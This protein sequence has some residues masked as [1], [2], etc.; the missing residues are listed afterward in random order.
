MSSPRIGRLGNIRLLTYNE[1]LAARTVHLLEQNQNRFVSVS[2]KSPRRH[3][4]GTQCNTFLLVG[5]EIRD[6]I[7]AVRENII[8]G[9]FSILPDAGFKAQA[10]FESHDRVE[11]Q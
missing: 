4:D 1:P 9:R 3:R 11:R 10:V 7:L 5:G 2:A 8:G 6:S